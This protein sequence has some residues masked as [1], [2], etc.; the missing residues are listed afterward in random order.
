MCT[1][2]T[3][4]AQRVGRVDS[5]WGGW[6]RGGSGHGLSLGQWRGMC[7]MSNWLSPCGWGGSMYYVPHL[8]GHAWYHAPLLTGMLVIPFPWCHNRPS[9]C[10]I[11]QQTTSSLWFSR[12]QRPCAHWHASVVRNNTPRVHPQCRPVAQ[13]AGRQVCVH[14]YAAHDTTYVPVIGLGRPLAHAWLLCKAAKQ[15]ACHGVASRSGQRHQRRHQ[16]AKPP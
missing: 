9:K 6:G 1:L 16:R 15:P 14:L 3:H 12:K 7:T 11:L 2:N 5:A 10:S 13:Q 8:V 4:R